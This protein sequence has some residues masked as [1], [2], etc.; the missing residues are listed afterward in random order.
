MCRGY[1][2][3]EYAMGGI[4][5]EKSDVFSFGVLLLE[6]VS[7]KKN[8]NFHHNEAHTSLLGHA[9]DLWNEGR[10]MDFVDQVLADS[11][12][13]QQVTRC[14]HIGLLCVQDHAADRPTMST[15]VL[16]LSSEIDLSTAETAYFY[17]PKLGRI[18]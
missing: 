16:M 1:M 9:W 4:F 10:A 3:P 17:F 12:S 8:N 2:S 6:I 14:L 13:L 7:S 15:V 11:C 5:S 18:I